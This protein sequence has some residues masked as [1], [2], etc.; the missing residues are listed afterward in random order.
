[1]AREALAAFE[2]AA[3]FNTQQV[4]VWQ[5]IAILKKQAGEQQAAITAIKKALRLEPDNYSLLQMF[6][7]LLEELLDEGDQRVLESLT[8]TLL[9]MNGLFP[10]DYWTLAHLGTAVWQ[11]GNEHEG[12]RLIQSALALKS[13]YTWAQLQLAQIYLDSKRWEDASFWL[14]EALRT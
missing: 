1:Q 14:Q 5:Q 4:A 6:A 8:Q 2:T 10:K 11:S 13:D 12:R 3:S 9:V 7:S